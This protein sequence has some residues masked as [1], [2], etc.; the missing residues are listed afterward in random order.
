MKNIKCVIATLSFSFMY[1]LSFAGNDVGN[2]GHVIVC[3]Q[4][5]VTADVAW[6]ASMQGFKFD[7]GSRNLSVEE[8]L[9][10]AL[11]RLRRVNPATAAFLEK[12][13]NSFWSDWAEFVEEPDIE[14]IKKGD[15]RT[16][17]GVVDTLGRDAGF[18]SPWV[19]FKDE[20]FSKY[21]LNVSEPNMWF[22]KPGPDCHYERLAINSGDFSEFVNRKPIL[23]RKSIYEKLDSDSKAAII[24]HELLSFNRSDRARKLANS[25]R[26]FTGQTKG[27]EIESV[28]A[29]N[30]LLLSK[31]ATEFNTDELRFQLL[32]TQLFRIELNGFFTYFPTPHKI[33]LETRVSSGFLPL[34]I[35]AAMY[36]EF[37]TITSHAN[38]N[39]ADVEYTDTGKADF[40]LSERN[41]LIFGQEAMVSP[42]S[43]ITERAN[44]QTVALHFFEDGTP[45]SF[46]F[47]KVSQNI[48]IPL[49]KSS[50]KILK[51]SAVFRDLQGVVVKAHNVVLKQPVFANVK[52]RSTFSDYGQAADTLFAGILATDGGRICLASYYGYFK[53]K[54]IGKDEFDETYYCR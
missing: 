47:G 8:K 27:Y 23:V 4:K 34:F 28:V 50:V 54:E 3:G 29:A 35:V 6:T 39:I 51:A 18:V 9:K 11:S 14:A 19:W 17:V 41:V 16:L 42:I 12:Q 53:I 24:L 48:E 49:G 52:I 13:I 46:I 26:L 31:E 1:S 43:T 25:S 37:Y 15:Y 22:R 30:S 32:A 21:N 45:Q 38:G 20:Y 33:Y 36:K 5:M 44:E 7:L 40:L 10:I 2:G